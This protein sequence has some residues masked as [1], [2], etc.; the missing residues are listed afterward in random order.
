MSGRDEN[1]AQRVVLSGKASPNEAAALQAASRSV[2]RQRAGFDRRRESRAENAVV[3]I[4][5][6]GAFLLGVG[7]GAVFAAAVLLE[8]F[9]CP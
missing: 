8:S 7:F 9:V 3:A 1:Y 5:A 2:A 6:S 4:V